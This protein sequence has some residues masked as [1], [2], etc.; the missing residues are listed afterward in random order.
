VKKSLTL[1]ASFSILA[2]LIVLPVIRS[3]NGSAGN[4]VTPV[5]SLIA[6]GSPMPNPLPPASNTD[7]LIA[8]GSPM[9]NPLPPA[10]NT[11]VLVAD[12]SPMPNPL[13]SGPHV[14][15]LTAIA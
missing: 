12:G 8:D 14:V 9:P 11:G 6:D 2:C 5:P 7:V 10:S 13:P 3:V 1:F 4:Y 15:E